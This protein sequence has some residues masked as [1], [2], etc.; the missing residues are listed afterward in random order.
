MGYLLDTNVLSEPAKPRPDP[1][2]MDW[3]ARV[4]GEQLYISCLTLG[5]L[6]KGALLVREPT[7]RKRFLDF[8]ALIA[9]DYADRI[10]GVDSLTGLLWGQLAA[11]ASRKGKTLPAIDA[12]LAAQ[13]MQNNLTL[14]T[15]NTKD[16]EHIDGLKLVNPWHA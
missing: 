1:A 5:E 3:F 8:T 12:L 2:Y 6:Q 11:H 16:F 7:K 13:A 9:K 4:P 15:R 14:V 10:I